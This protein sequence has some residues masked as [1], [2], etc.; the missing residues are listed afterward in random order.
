[1]GPP[2]A[3]KA[4]CPRCGSTSI[5]A[6]ALETKKLGQAYAMEALFGTAAGVAAGAEMVIQVFCLYCGCLWRPGTP[7]ERRLRALSG[8][9]GEQA[10]VAEEKAVAKE[11]EEHQTARV[12]DIWLKPGKK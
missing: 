9:L 7:Q 3:P 12:S 11:T 8:Q 1:M 6:L 10:K 2:L 5:Q 4:I